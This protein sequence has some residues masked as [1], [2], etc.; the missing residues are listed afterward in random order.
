M[1]RRGYEVNQDERVTEGNS[2]SDF[3]NDFEVVDK[4]DSQLLKDIAFMEELV[5]VEVLPTDNP[6]AEALIQLSCNG[7]NQL[8]IRGIPQVVKRKFIEILARAKTES[9]STPE[10]MDAKGNR[11]ATV[12]RSQGLRYPFRVL[13]DENVNGRQWLES[14]MREAV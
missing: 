3:K 11:M 6:H 2:L 4:A 8:L 1:A 14:V 5:E 10:I 13:S 9:I 7:I 12:R